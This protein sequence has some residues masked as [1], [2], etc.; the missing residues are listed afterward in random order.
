[1]VLA[2]PCW[3]IDA[4]QVLSYVLRLLVVAAFPVCWRGSGGAGGIRAMLAF[5]LTIPTGERLK[6]R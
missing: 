4:C 1:V 5:A 6:S 3:R 2:Y